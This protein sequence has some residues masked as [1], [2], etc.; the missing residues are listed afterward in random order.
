MAAPSAQVAEQATNLLQNL[1]LDSESK[2]SEIPDAKQLPQVD[3]G[4]ATSSASNAA[5]SVTPSTSNAVPPFPHD[6]VVEQ[7]AMYY[8]GYPP[9]QHYFY[10][11]GY[12]D[13]YRFVNPDG[14]EIPGTGVYGDS[15]SLVYHQ[16]YGYPPHMPYGPY[17][18]AGTPVPTMGTDGH[19]YGPQ[20]FQYNGPYYQQTIPS[21]P[22]YAPSVTPPLPQPE[23][24][25]SSTEQ[26]REDADNANANVTTNVNGD[27]GTAGP[28]PSYPMYTVPPNGSHGR[29]LLPPSHDGSRPSVPWIDATLASDGHVR[30]PPSSGAMC[31]V[32]Q[33]T[34]PGPIGQSSRPIA[35]SVMGA[36]HLRQPPP[37]RP[38]PGYLNRMYSS[39]RA[40]PNNNTFRSAP[41]GNNGYVPRPI[42]RGWGLSD[43]DRPR[44]RGNGILYGYNEGL[45][46]LNEQNR[47]P[48]TARFR[49][50]RTNPVSPWQVKGQNTT[51]NGNSDEA[52]VVPNRDQY[53]RPEFVTKYADAKFFIIKSYSED[54]IH[55]SI[56]YN[57]WASTPNGNKKLDAAY[58]ESQEKSTGCP[59]FLFF[60]VNA[61]GQ[62]CGVAEMTGPV[63]FNQS[64]DFWQQDKWSGRFSVKWHIVKDVPNNQLRHITLENNDNKPV[65]NSR[66]TQE[67]MFEKGIE[68][69][70]IFKDYVSKTSIL[71]DFV[72][73]E[74]R[75]KAMQEKRARN[76][77]LF[78]QRQ[79]T[80]IHHNVKESS[81]Q[82]GSNPTNGASSEDKDSNV[83]LQQPATSEKN[84][85]KGQSN[86]SIS[87][88]DRPATGASSDLWKGGK[89]TLLKRESN[90]SAVDKPLQPNGS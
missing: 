16:S 72:F 14:V 7:P 80:S 6:F 51:A 25:T 32:P 76:Q 41:F 85:L 53:N 27:V 11:N 66:D 17:S 42:G 61:S 12:E 67:V 75:Q 79:E 19:L 5:T 58:K 35:P 30:P 18:G 22:P 77:M 3:G 1:S 50:Q 73:Y 20:P 84:F 40:L 9:Q 48:R 60:S 52:N 43:K 21:G 57:V 49:N 78:Q 65:T 71:D 36:P 31:N 88:E 83:R 23:V 55:K 63:D 62:F 46:I 70:K 86:R 4:E 54:D 59:I 28:R 47:G 82:D 90:G 33:S 68:M 37:V 39:S 10:G 64:V 29:G 15:N 44:G 13:E 87:S 74:G 56:K 89:P 24:S 26:V 2:P 45:D 8:G 38:N 81:H 34:S 69:L